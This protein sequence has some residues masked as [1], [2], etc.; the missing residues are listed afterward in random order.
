[1]ASLHQKIPSIRFSD[2]KLLSFLTVQFSGRGPDRC[3]PFFRTQGV[4]VYPNFPFA[5]KVASKCHR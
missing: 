5:G 4:K 2:Q 3:A 1:L